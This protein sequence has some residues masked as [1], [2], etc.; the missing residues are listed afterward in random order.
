MTI[1]LLYVVFILTMFNT[2]FFMPRWVTTITFPKTFLLIP[3][4]NDSWHPMRSAINYLKEANHKKGLYE[5]VFFKAENRFLYPPTSL[6]PVYLFSKITDHYFL[7]LKGISWVCIIA[8]IIFVSM[9]FRWGIGTF[10]NGKISSINKPSRRDE[11]IIMLS[12]GIVTVLFYPIMKA[13]ELGQIQTWLNAMF[14]VLFYCYL[15]NWQAPAGI[16]LGLM[17]LVKP[18]YALIFVWGILRKKWQLVLCFLSIILPALIIS[19]LLFGIENHLEF[20]SVVSFLSKRGQAYYPN[21][22]MN[23]LLNRL[24]HYGDMDVLKWQGDVLPPV[25]MIVYA[26]SI[27][28][29]MILVPLAFL[30]P[31][32]AKKEG[33]IIDLSIIALTSTIISPT[34]W[35]HH[36]GILLPIYAFVFSY[37]LSEDVLGKPVRPY[38]WILA[39]SYLLTSN[40]IAGLQ[41]FADQPYWNILLS[42]VFFGALILLVCLVR[43]MF[44]NNLRLSTQKI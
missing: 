18:H 14:A 38:L 11:I 25:N 1:R 23:G 20:S 22:S 43:F 4:Q 12:I 40:F 26:G 9:I 42:Y 36:Y 31:M 28:F 8:T 30:L 2:I 3:K 41:V 24:I 15:R 13:Y 35:E 7:I 32:R 21:Q 29:A 10:L 16:I 19:C 6:L 39:I 27:G 5:E 37:L 44:E 33:H 17:C 34:A